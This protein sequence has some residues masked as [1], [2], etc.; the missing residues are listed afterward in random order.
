MEKIDLFGIFS[1]LFPFGI[2]RIFL[3]VLLTRSLH[4]SRIRVVTYFHGIRVTSTQAKD[5]NG[6]LK[7]DG[8]KQKLQQIKGRS[9]KMH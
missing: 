3:W 9:D 1:F 8:L 2:F 6:K 5:A 7:K 4:L